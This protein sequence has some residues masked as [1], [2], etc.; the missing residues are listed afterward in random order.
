MVH[1]LSKLCGSWAGGQRGGRRLPAAAVALGLSL[2]AGRAAAQAS[3]SGT[4]FDDV[5]Y[6]GGAGRDYATANSSATGF[7][8]GAI[9]RPGATVELYNSAGL[10]VGTTTTSSSGLYT[11]GGLAADTYTVRVVSATV[12][13]ARPG[14]P[15]AGLLPVQ[16]FRTTNGAADGSRVGGEN[17]ARTDADANTGVVTTNTGSNNMTVTFQGL[18]GAS[19]VDN[20]LFL[21]NVEVLQGGTP[22]ATNPLANP[23]FE[24]GTLTDN[25]GTY[26]YN[27]TNGV[28]WTFAASAGI[29]SNNSAFT[30]PNTSYGARAGFV[31]SLGTSNGQISQ[32][33]TL[34]AGTYTLRFQAANRINFSGQ[35]TVRVT[36]NGTTV[37]ASLQP[38]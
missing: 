3:L 23:G 30:P 31:Q 28:G 18:S 27:P 21:D 5:N 13:S 14:N 32:V 1:Y 11:F 24:D 12:T 29:Q 35:Q 15:A 20:T 4:V 22:L 8:A 10:L 16:T 9:A 6:G 37:L 34:P 38:A 26:Q 33:F 7:A 2:L 19:R 25:G 17:P 36:V